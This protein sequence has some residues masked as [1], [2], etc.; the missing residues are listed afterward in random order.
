MK[1]LERNSGNQDL[2]PLHRRV[3]ITGTHP[4]AETPVGSLRNVRTHIGDRIRGWKQAV[5]LALALSLPLAVRADTPNTEDGE[6][7]KIE[8]VGIDDPAGNTSKQTSNTE[9][10]EK[11]TEQARFS[12][13]LEYI[14]AQLVKDSAIQEEV[15]KFKSFLSGNTEGDKD[16]L[17]RMIRGLDTE[18]S[19]HPLKKQF[20]DL[21]RAE[22]RK[23]DFSS[24]DGFLEELGIS[25]SDEEKWAFYFYI[26]SLLMGL[27]IAFDVIAS[28]IGRFKKST[29]VAGNLG[30]AAELGASH[31][32]LPVAAGAMAAL[33]INGS[34]VLGPDIAKLI[35]RAVGGISVYL[36]ARI[37]HE[38]IFKGDEDE[39]DE[40]ENGVTQSRKTIRARILANLISM[41]AV[42]AD[43]YSSGFAKY[44][45][46]ILKYWKPEEIQKSIVIG[47]AVV[48]ICSMISGLA[49]L[50]LNRKYKEAISGDAHYSPELI[51]RIQKVCLAGES[52]VL[53]YF[54]L[55]A[56][57]NQFLSMGVSRPWVMLLSAL[58]TAG[59]LKWKE[60][61]DSK[62]Q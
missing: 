11:S 57:L 10:N 41:W 27:G 20:D 42:S 59:V 47:G 55:N 28:N 45:E 56:G 61:S 9:D 4:H 19:N 60:M 22:I 32:G 38:E 35:E 33:A 15:S 36:I 16:E 12:P 49:A 2:L 48:A 39:V 31:I 52:S 17:V 54:A 26:T 46:T 3:G 13:E 40:T 50:K 29:S 8:S 6:K 14:F 18:L 21:V 53:G 51:Q 24:L 43:A 25:L 30:W 62:K 7:A 34:T 44:I 5:P 1:K 58:G 37:L 23:Q